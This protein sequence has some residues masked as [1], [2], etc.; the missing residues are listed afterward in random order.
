[1][2]WIQ[3][4]R[5]SIGMNRV[6]FARAITEQ[7][8]GSGDRR[9]TVPA[10]LIRMLEE[11]P[12]CVTH[13]KIA[14]VIARACGATPEQRDMI[15]HK[16]HRGKWHGVSGPQV[17]YDLPKS[18]R[19]RPIIK[20]EPVPGD[21]YAHNLKSVVII[22]RM[23]N[24]VKRCASGKEAA[25]FMGLSSTTVYSRC[26]HATPLE[27]TLHHPYTCRYAQEWDRLTATA[28]AASVRRSLE[29]AGDKHTRPVGC[30][31]K[32]PVVV[33]DRTGR[34]LTRYSTIGEASRGEA[35]DGNCIRNRC[36]RRV[37]QE[38]RGI[39]DSTYRYA[40]EWDAM[41]REEQLKDIGAV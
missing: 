12:R 3:E 15:V 8:G 40:E 23:G 38:F 9:V 11:W 13:P 20:A 41:S 10:T 34:E 35:F 21:K 17:V 36:M 32:R 37:K 22:D 24:E 5:E 27:F 1:M 2:T 19:P 6:Q 25:E 7:L 30:N 16:R 39:N 26:A 14:N 31:L 33:I 4:Y 18:R 29:L 28:K